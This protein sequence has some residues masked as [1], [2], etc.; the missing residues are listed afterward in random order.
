MNDKK[1][2]ATATDWMRGPG[3]YYEV[4]SVVEAFGFP[5]MAPSDCYQLAQDNLVEIDKFVLGAN[6][7]EIDEVELSAARDKAL[8]LMWVA[9]S[10]GVSE[11]CVAISMHIRAELT[12]SSTMGPQREL[13]EQV[14]ERWMV[15]GDKT[16]PVTA[17]AT[18]R[19]RL[20]RSA[21]SEE[22]VLF[23]QMD[24]DQPQSPSKP[25]RIVRS[26]R[27]EKT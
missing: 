14:A 25:A 1:N 4:E 27:I 7:N 12:A 20:V 22:D 24:F 26:S 13:L 18:S 8:V 6:K 3:D 17:K 9:A 16:V 19:I 5:Q 15:I 2:Q 11:A 21:Q 10:R 23:D